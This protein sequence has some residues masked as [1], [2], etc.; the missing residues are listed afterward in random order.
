L[1]SP[2]LRWAAHPSFPQLVRDHWDD[3]RALDDVGKPL[4][5]VG[6]APPLPSTTEAGE[7]AVQTREQAR[8]AEIIEHLFTGELSDSDWLTYATNV[9]TGRLLESKTR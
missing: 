2:A 6:E 1:R 9:I 5:A 7:G 8:L 4:L 3:P